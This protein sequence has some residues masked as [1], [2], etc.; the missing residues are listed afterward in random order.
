MKKKNIKGTQKSTIIRPTTL[1]NKK[2]FLAFVDHKN[3]I[4]SNV[5]SRGKSPFNIAAKQ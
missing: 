1:S 2:N 3:Y 5:V 4:S